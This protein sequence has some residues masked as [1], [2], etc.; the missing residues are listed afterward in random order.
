M[1]EVFDGAVVEKQLS[2]LKKK[3]I[4]LFLGWVVVTSKVQNLFVF[5]Q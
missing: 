2:S 1:V 5:G 3:K 4:Q